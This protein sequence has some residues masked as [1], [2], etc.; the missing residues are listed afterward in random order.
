MSNHAQKAAA[1]SSRKK[2]ELAWA[3]RKLA[4]RLARRLRWGAMPAVVPLYLLF[5]PLDSYLETA[6]FTSCVYTVCAL[7][8]VYGTFL[9]VSFKCPKCGKRFEERWRSFP[10]RCGSCG[11]LAGT[12]P[13]SVDQDHD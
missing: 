9:V 13:P 6:F 3:E 10:D 7:A 12:I 8:G 11:I 2:Y 4:R 5:K 1:I